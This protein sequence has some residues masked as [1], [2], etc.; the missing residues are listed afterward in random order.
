[1]YL[2]HAPLPDEGGHIVAP[3]A[4]DSHLIRPETDSSRVQFLRSGRV[5]NRLLKPWA[6]LDLVTQFRAD[7]TERRSEYGRN[8]R[9]TVQR[10]RP[11]V[12]TG[13][14]D[15]LVDGHAEETVSWTQA[16]L[17]KGGERQG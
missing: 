14:K 6:V 17:L 1:M 16:A 9:L 15:A 10:G 7:Y 8:G 13:C 4:L 5:E 12:A 3:Y 11:A 2:S